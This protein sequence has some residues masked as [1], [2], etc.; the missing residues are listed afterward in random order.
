M[1]GCGKLTANCRSTR[2][3]KIGTNILE[4]C[5]VRPEK[6]A[7]LYT[8][9]PLNDTFTNNEDQDKMPHNVVFH[10]GLHCL[11]KKVLQTKIQYIF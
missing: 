5:G 3:I 11:L 6:K 1:M 2:A 10:Q 9:N 8:S 4:N 7:N